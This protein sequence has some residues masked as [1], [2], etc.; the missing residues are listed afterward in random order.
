MQW[1]NNLPPL[2]VSGYLAYAVTVY[3]C[4]WQPVQWLQLE[5]RPQVI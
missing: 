2:F 4:R 1:Q 5:N 3:Q